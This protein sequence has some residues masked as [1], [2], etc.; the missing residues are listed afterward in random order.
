MSLDLVAP[1]SRTMSPQGWT[2]VY[3]GGSDDLASAHIDYGPP[4]RAS[5]D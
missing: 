4:E 5:N 2:V 3:R 1:P